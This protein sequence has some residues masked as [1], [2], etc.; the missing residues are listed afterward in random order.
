MAMRKQ[1]HL[2]P[3]MEEHEDDREENGA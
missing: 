3:I 2:M 1:Q